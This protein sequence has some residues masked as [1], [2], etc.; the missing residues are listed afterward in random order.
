MQLGGG[1]LWSNEPDRKRAA[2]LHDSLLR[3]GIP[4]FCLM[5][6]LGQKIPVDYDDYFDAIVLDAPCS[7]EGTAFKSLSALSFW[8]RED[9]NSIVSIQ[10]ALITRAISLLRP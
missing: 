6:Y 7:G 3:C 8:R 9:I 4:A 5:N 1:Y 10:K 2:T